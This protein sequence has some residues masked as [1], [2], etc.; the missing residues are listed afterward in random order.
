MNDELVTVATYSSIEE[1]YIVKGM[2]ETNGV[3]TLVVND[4]NLYVPIFNGI[5]LQVRESD[6]KKAEALIAASASF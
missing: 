4:D 5:R 6:Q 1:A 2:L 3:P